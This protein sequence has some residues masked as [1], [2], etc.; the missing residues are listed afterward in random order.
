[1]SIIRKLLLFQLLFLLAVIGYTKN[2]SQVTVSISK[3][4]GYIGEPFEISVIVKS[5]E[6]ADDITMDINADNFEILSKKS[7]KP[8]QNQSYNLFEKRIKIVF[9]KTGNY[10]I[11]PIKVNLLKGKKVIEV[12]KTNPLD[13]TIIS[14][15]KDGENN[16]KN[17]KPLKPLA[18]VSGTILYLLKY[19]FFILLIA[20]LVYLIVMYFK[21][22]YGKYKYEDIPKLSPVEEYKKEWEKLKSTQFIK[23]GKY[24]FYFITLTE[25]VKKFL[26]KEY[27]FNAEELT[28][29]ETLMEL[30]VL[31]SEE[32]LRDK[33]NRLLDLSDKVKFAKYIPS[34]EDMDALEKLS[35]EILD[36]YFERN[37]ERE[38]IEAENAEKND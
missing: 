18:K 17:L 31:E 3:L 34:S 22:R 11:K 36:E 8:N 32:L 24:K 6:G 27:D 20:L 21:K 14:S 19:L 38:R 13:I 29:F 33:F 28:S 25:I 2:S 4:R 9:W 7:I 10:K 37:K 23:N 30:K 1:M 35:D 5:Q 26:S 12:L 15:L 16:E